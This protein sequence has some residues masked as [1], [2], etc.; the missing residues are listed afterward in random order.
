MAGLVFGGERYVEK[1]RPILRS[2]E[3]TA[4]RPSLRRL[5]VRKMSSPE[6]VGTAVADIA[7]NELPRRRRRLHL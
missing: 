5:K 2:E 7:R 1:I 6:E 3:A 4:E